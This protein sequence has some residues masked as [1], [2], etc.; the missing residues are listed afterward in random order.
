MKKLSLFVLFVLCVSL[1]NAS[2]LVV[3]YEDDKLIT[4]LVDDIVQEDTEIDLTEV[5]DNY[6][7]VDDYFVGSNSEEFEVFGVANN[8]RLEY[9]EIV[10]EISFCNYNTQ[11]EPCEGDCTLMEAAFTCSDCDAD[12]GVCVDLTDGIC[13]EDCVN[14]YDCEV[15]SLMKTV[16]KELPSQEG[17]KGTLDLGVSNEYLADNLGEPKNVSKTEYYLTKFVD[18]TGMSWL[19]WLVIL[20]LIGLA[21]GVVILGTRLKGEKEGYLNRV[22][23][24]INKLYKMGYNTRQ[25]KTY[26]KT[27]N[28]TDDQ[29]EDV[30]KRAKY[31]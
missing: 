10:K 6:L 15:E 3:D 20:V 25:I 14:D 12:D 4:Y 7:K 31:D 2:L 30:M 21:V 24:R 27:L 9:R 18:R 13:D 28:L 29:I 8:I 11:C 26:L 17:V 1:V 5:F 19:T 23:I 22:V 16:E